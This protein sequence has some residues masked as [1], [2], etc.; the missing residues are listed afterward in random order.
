MLR[1]L[2]VDDDQVVVRALRRALLTKRPDWLVTTQ[3]GAAAALAILAREPFE[4]VV[5]DYEMPEMNGVE[6]FRRIKR[7]FPAMLRVI[8]SG[9]ARD[10]A[11]I[12]PPGLLH[13]WL[14][15]SNT[16][17]DLAKAIEELL[18]RRDKSKRSRRA[19]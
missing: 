16:A 4:V 5:S 12:I 18:L 19:G 11:G 10:S 8:V 6:L 2:L 17:D 3:S 13:G 7:Q 14:Q 1:V 15:K 9:K